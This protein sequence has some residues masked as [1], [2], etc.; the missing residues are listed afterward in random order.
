VAALTGATRAMRRGDH[1]QVQ[2]MFRARVLAQGFTVLAMVAGGIY[3][4]Q[5]RKQEREL[6]KV[7]QEQKEE[8]R[9]QKWIRELEARDEED[10]AIK[11]LMD[12]KRSQ[13][14]G[15]KGKD[16][17]GAAAEKDGQEGSGSGSVL[18]SLGGWFGG[19]KNDDA[20][21]GGKESVDGKG[22]TTPEAK[23]AAKA[24]FEESKVGAAIA[25]AEARSQ[26][27]AP[28]KKSSTSGVSDSL[29]G[30]FARERAGQ[31]SSDEKPID[32]LKSQAAKEMD[33]KAPTTASK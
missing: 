28:E 2:R 7:Q 27:G 31:G 26:P 8:E 3:L 23:D 30:L 32:K 13:A 11:S 20:A 12:R 18:G 5:E 1:K 16:D 17:K 4:G 29:R 22:K 10:K 24:A 19:K 21:A 25:K 14:A 9:R 15:R 6:W 33:P